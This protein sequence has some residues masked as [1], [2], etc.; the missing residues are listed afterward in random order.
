MRQ[1]LRLDQNLSAITSCNRILCSSKNSKIGLTSKMNISTLV[2]IPTRP[3][4]HHP[5][6]TTWVVNCGREAPRTTKHHPQVVL[7]HSQGHCTLLSCKVQVKYRLLLYQTWYRCVPNMISNSSCQSRR[8]VLYR[9]LSTS[10]LFLT[11]SMMA[12]SNLADP[13]MMSSPPKA[14]QSMPR[15]R[16]QQEH[17]F[18]WQ[19]QTSLCAQLVRITADFSRKILFYSQSH[20]PSKFLWWGS[21]KFRFF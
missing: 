19:Q 15:C 20:L 6:W 7:C 11:S 9:T 21:W 8:K 1:A 2:T 13:L 12:N 18:A 16:L 3:S 10:P 5:I 4:P 17:H 14:K